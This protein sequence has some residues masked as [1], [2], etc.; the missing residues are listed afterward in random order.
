MTA[1]YRGAEIVLTRRQIRRILFLLYA[2]WENDDSPGEGIDETDNFAERRAEVLA[3]VETPEEL[4]I[5]SMAYNWDDGEEFLQRVIDHPLCDQGTGLMLFWLAEPALLYGWEAEA[6]KT[7]VWRETLAFIKKVQIKYLE[8][9]FGNHSVKVDPRNMF[10]VDHTKPE[11]GAT[12]MDLVP[13]IMKL[14][15]PGEPVSFCPF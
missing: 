9:G 8:N 7:T 2:Y 13:E 11:A 14:P 6:K 5:F 1:L 4:H 3:E 15:S 10:G 12:G